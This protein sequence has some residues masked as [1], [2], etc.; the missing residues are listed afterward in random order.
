[1]VTLSIGMTIGV[2]KDGEVFHDYCQQALESLRVA[3]FTEPVH[4]FLEPGAE[5]H[6]PE[7]RDNLILH[8]NERQLG[9]FQ[10]FRHGLRH[11]MVG[12]QSDYY[13]MLQDDALW[14]PGAAATLWAKLAEAK[15]AKLGCLSPYTSRAMVNPKVKVK[16]NEDRKP[17]WVDCEFYHRAFWGAVAL[18]FP[19]AAAAA[20]ESKSPRYRN[21]DHSRKLDVVVGNAL[22]HD[23]RLKIL[24][25]VPSLVQHI[26][27]FSTLGRHKFKSNQW[28]RKGFEFEKE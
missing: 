19:H 17:M 25:H 4:L 23:L 20:M 3:G 15:T 9:C 16:Y 2:R 6:L 18:C 10:N 13:L 21:H 7:S 8:Q 11:L 14:A 1:M 5:R 28:G 26:G 24:V 27:T 12:H 22:K